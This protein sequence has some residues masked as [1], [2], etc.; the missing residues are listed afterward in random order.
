MDPPPE[1]EVGPNAGRIGYLPTGDKVEWVKDKDDSGQEIE[2][3]LVLRRN[4]ADILAAYNE[5]W[6]KV[7]WNRHQN[8]KHAIRTGAEPL[9]NEQKALFQKAM[10]AARRIEKKYG[11][12]KIICDIA[13]YL[14]SAC[15]IYLPNQDGRLPAPPCQRPP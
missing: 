13:S 9:K 6:N 7:W 3:P 15:R 12:K 4:D 2:W 8:W 14:W 10:R 11:R 1:G 5:F